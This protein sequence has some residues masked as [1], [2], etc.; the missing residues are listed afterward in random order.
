[1]SEINKLKSINEQVNEIQFNL[2]RVLRFRE[3]IFSKISQA[4]ELLKQNP[5]NKKARRSLVSC[6]NR[7]AKFLD[8]IRRGSNEGISVLKDT[9][10]ELK[11]AE[12]KPADKEMLSN[13]IL[14]LI[15]A[16]RFAKRKIKVIEKRVLQGERLE[17]KDYANKYFNKFLETLKEEEELDEEIAQRL[18]GVLNRIVPPLRALALNSGLGALGGVLGV[19]A[20]AIPTSIMLEMAKATD[21]AAKMQDVSEIGLIVVIL[22]SAI[23]FLRVFISSSTYMAHEEKLKRYEL[24][25]H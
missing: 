10:K 2:N 5:N 22:G 23:G 13:V 12:V 17:A 20:S 6:L 1:M 11:G 14:N 25:K 3:E 15:D 4:S 19:F 8:I 18:R 21:N 9:S 24:S 7:E 16:M